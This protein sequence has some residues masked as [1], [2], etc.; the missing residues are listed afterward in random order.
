[1]AASRVRKMQT[2]AASKFRKLC[3]NHFEQNNSFS[4]CG[5]EAVIPFPLVSMRG[6]VV[7]VYPVTDSLL[8][9]RNSLRKSLTC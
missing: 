2:T 7:N 8:Y 6:E 9:R 4:S 1:M 5:R 3:S